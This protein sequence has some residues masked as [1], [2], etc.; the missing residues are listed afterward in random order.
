MD[1]RFCSKADVRW[2]IKLSNEIYITSTNYLCSR[3]RT[4]SMLN[5]G[6][7]QQESIRASWTVDRVARGKPQRIRQFEARIFPVNL[8]ASNL[9]RW[10]CSCI[11]KSVSASAGIWSSTG[12]MLAA[13]R[14]LCGYSVFWVRCTQS[15][16]P[17]GSLCSS[18]PRLPRRQRAWK[19]PFRWP[20]FFP[21]T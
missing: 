21:F 6:L 2:I 17:P 18:R 4:L 14:S 19:E 20:T 3:W 8:T 1:T 15:R 9:Q 5:A 7:I 10:K 13:R 12:Q 11:W 16:R